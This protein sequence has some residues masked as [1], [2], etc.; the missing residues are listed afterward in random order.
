MR[1]SRR[2]SQAAIFGVSFFNGSDLWSS[3]EAKRGVLVGPVERYALQQKLDGQRAG[4]AALDDGLY[5]VGGEICEPQEPADMRFAEAM[6]LRNLSG[7]GE[8][9]LL[10]HAHP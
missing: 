4:L 3:T 10:Q 1:H 9:T 8:F 2:R 5:D 7:I 6:A